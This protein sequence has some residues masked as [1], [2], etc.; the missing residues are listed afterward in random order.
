MRKITLLVASLFVAAIGFAQEDVIDRIPDNSTG[1]IATLGDDGT[2]IYCGDYFVLDEATTLGEVT[3]YGLASTP[4]MG[5]FVEGFNVYIYE[6]VA[7]KPAGNP[8]LS[9][10][11]VVELGEIDLS[12]FTMIEDGQY[13]DFIVDFTAVNGSEVTLPAGEYWMVGFPNVIGGPAEAGRWNW[14]GSLS[15]APAELPKLID[16]SDLFGAGATDWM[17]I[18]ILIAPD[19]FPSF[20]WK[21]TGEAGVVGINDNFAESVSVFPNP[22]TDVYNIS[23]PAG[24]EVISSSLVDVMGRTTGVTYNNGQMNVSSLA[25]GVYFM[26]IETTQ[27]SFTQKV[28]KQ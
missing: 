21:L 26:N 14:F 20:A 25:Q 3:F 9:G 19:P 23:L 11:G 8:E 6:N 18:E 2:G 5:V 15:S 10:T 4:G 1:L 22:T 28:V 17:D 27:G 7:G 24:A 16:P 13:V 12:D